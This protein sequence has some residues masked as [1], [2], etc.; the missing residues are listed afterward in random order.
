MNYLTHDGHRLV[1]K[2]K[3]QTAVQDYLISI[4]RQLLEGNF[5]L[6]LFKKSV[7]A[8][9]KELN[10]EYSRCKPIEAYW[11]E[12]EKNDHKLMGVG[13]S[14]YYIYHSKNTY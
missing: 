8:K 7:L 14:T 11:W 1:T 2:N 5:K 12:C 13:F 4:D 9:I 6:K 3:L 10:Q